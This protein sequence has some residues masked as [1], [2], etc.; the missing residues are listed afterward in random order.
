MR[1][2]DQPN[3]HYANQLAEV[4]YPYRV[5]NR[6]TEAVGDLNQATFCS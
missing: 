6:V 4:N 1:I 3:D 2:I 5:A